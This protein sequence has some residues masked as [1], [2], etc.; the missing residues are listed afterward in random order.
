MHLPQVDPIHLHLALVHLPVLGMPAVL[1][2]WVLA[3][4]RDDSFWRRVFEAGWT[5]LTLAAAAAYYAGGAALERLQPT[6]GAP[7]PTLPLAE[8]HATAGRAALIVLAL[9]TA[10]LLQAWML[11]RQGERPTGARRAALGLGLAA[12][13]LLLTTAWLGGPVGHIELR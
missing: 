13:L 12:C 7:W 9:S 11:E 4:R 2:A 1:A 8:N 3:W 5:G 6:G 10:A